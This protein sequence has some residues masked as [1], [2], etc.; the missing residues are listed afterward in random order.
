ME[1]AGEFRQELRSGNKST[2]QQV[3]VVKGLMSN[4]LGLPAITSLGQI[5]RVDAVKKYST[6]VQRAQPKVFQG[7]GKFGEQYS[8]HLQADA[9]PLCLYTPRRVPLSFRQK[10]KEELY[11]METLGVISKV[12]EPTKWCS[13][14]VAVSKKTGSVRICVDLQTLN[15][16]VQ[17]EIHPLLCMLPIM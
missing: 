12:D 14:M 5:A 10:V 13:G 4:L 1:V 8:I 7:L 16:S 9:K 17:R 11:R 6:A 3:F 2:S 15:E